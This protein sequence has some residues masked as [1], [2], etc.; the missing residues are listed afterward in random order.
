MTSNLVEL[1]ESAAKIRGEPTVPR[2]YIVE[3]LDKIDK[4]EVEVERYPTGIP[5]LKNVYD[6]ASKIYKEIK[7]K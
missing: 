3:A 1:V 6:L 2:D 7:I 5:S 4:K